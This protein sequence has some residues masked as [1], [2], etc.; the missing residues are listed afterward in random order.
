M[1]TKIFIWHGGNHPFWLNLN[2]G[3]SGVAV[4]KALRLIIKSTFS[5]GVLE[6][7]F[8]FPSLLLLMLLTAFR[9]LATGVHINK[10]TAKP[11]ETRK[12]PSIR[13]RPL[14]YCDFRSP[15]LTTGQSIICSKIGIESLLS[16][17]AAAVLKHGVFQLGN[18]KTLY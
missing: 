10:L 2:G 13:W 8:F 16:L 11:L 4:I 1:C 9:A 18:Y 7:F 3:E 15:T 17:S 14:N 6:C 5:N 12:S